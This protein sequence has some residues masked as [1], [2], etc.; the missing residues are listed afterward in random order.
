MSNLFTRDW[1]TALVHVNHTDLPHVHAAGLMFNQPSICTC[2]RTC[3]LSTQ[4]IPHCRACA[5][6]F[7]HMCMLQGLQQTSSQ[8]PR[9]QP[10]QQPQPGHPSPY[11]ADHRTAADPRMA[12]AKAPSPPP[13][14]PPGAPGAPAC[15]PGGP[16]TV[17]PELATAGRLPLPGSSRAGTPPVKTESKVSFVCL[18]EISAVAHHWCC[19]HV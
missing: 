18:C 10:P 15:P 16:T 19:Y 8:Q 11:P 6:P 2:C 3:I 12:A 9:Q 1:T 5:L 7:Q 17:K 4:R 13:G 14:P